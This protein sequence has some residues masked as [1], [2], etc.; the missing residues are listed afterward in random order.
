MR[1]GCTPPRFQY[2]R[3][4]LAALPPKQTENTFLRGP[5]APAPPICGLWVMYSSPAGRGGQGGEGLPGVL[6]QSDKKVYT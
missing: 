3:F 2:F 4:V 1:M 5:E 6:M